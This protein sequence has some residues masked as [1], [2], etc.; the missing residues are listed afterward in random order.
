MKPDADAALLGTTRRGWVAG[1]GM[2]RVILIGVW[3]FALHLTQESIPVN[4]SLIYHV[5]YEQVK[6]GND[7]GGSRAIP[8]VNSTK[9]GGISAFCQ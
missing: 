9:I 2:I 3:T 4:I 8:G 5:I 6:C 7:G 1:V